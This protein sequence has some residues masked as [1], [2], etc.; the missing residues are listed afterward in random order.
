VLTK[1]IIQKID[2]LDRIYCS[3]ATN[4]NLSIDVTYLEES[5]KELTLK[6]GDT[7][8]FT[9]GKVYYEEYTL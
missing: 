2:T 8:T 9:S 3:N 7:I 5:M 6:A 1:A 4:A